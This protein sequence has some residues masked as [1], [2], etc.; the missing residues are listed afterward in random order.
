M[1]CRCGAPCVTASERSRHTCRACFAA[2]QRARRQQGRDGWLR[3]RSAARAGGPPLGVTAPRAGAKQPG[4]TAP[5]PRLRDH[6]EVLRLL[7][8]L[9]REGKKNSTTADPAAVLALVERLHPLL[10]NDGAPIVA[11]SLAC[12]F[13]EGG[14]HQVCACPPAVGHA[15]HHLRRRY[16]PAYDLGCARKNQRRFER[17]SGCNTRTRDDGATR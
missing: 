11:Q 4:V 14:K 5:S 17:Q 3:A 12:L 8:A 1:T 10:A 6:A 13:E 7:K 2:Y 15:A 9:A 16:D